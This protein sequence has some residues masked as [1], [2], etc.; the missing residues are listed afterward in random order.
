MSNR[1][2]LSG[3]WNF[4]VCSK[5]WKSASNSDFWMSKFTDWFFSNE[6]ISAAQKM[7]NTLWGR[8]ISF[9]H[10]LELMTL[11]SH[12]HHFYLEHCVILNST[13]PKK[14]VKRI[15]NGPQAKVS[16]TTTLRNKKGK[17][18]PSNNSFQSVCR[19]PTNLFNEDLSNG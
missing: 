12:N 13:T 19:A 8:K 14:V 7:K 18:W 15:A 6:K 9:H 17:N 3:L 11:F 1:D 5:M 16:T 10:S 2:I 4:T